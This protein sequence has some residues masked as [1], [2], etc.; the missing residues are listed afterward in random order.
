MGY[1]SVNDVLKEQAQERVKQIVKAI[2]AIKIKYYIDFSK[3][4]KED[5]E[6]YQKL[7]A[8]LEQISASY[9]L[10][11]LKVA[12]M[13]EVSAKYDRK[14]DDSLPA[15]KPDDVLEACY[16]AIDAQK[17]ALSKGKITQARKCQEILSRYMEKVTSEKY[18]ELIM[19]YKREKFAE[20]MNSR[21]ELEAKNEQWM[22]IM[23]GFYKAGHVMERNDVVQVIGDAPQKEQQR[24]NNREN[25]SEAIE[26]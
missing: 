7:E 10:D 5:D 23:N 11:R 22:K 3:I 21:D 20:L 19:N 25:L 16:G 24:N 1:E 18:Q 8:S 14:D 6:K 17:E 13:G 2:K 4:S 15:N 9:D 12:L 26:L